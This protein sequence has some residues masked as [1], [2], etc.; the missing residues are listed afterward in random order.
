MTLRKCLSIFCV[1]MLLF[2]FSACSND[3]SEISKSSFNKN[4]GLNDY[5]QTTIDAF[6]NDDIE[7]IK[8]IFCKNVSDSHNLNDEIQNAF[9][10]IDGNIISYEK[11]NSEETGGTRRD[12]ETIRR[13]G[14]SDIVGIKTDSGKSY[15]ILLLCV[16]EYS[17]D[18]SHIGVQDISVYEVNYTSENYLSYDIINKITV[19]GVLD[20]S[21]D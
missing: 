1:L 20:G 16:L 3:I 9:D 12:G 10:F 13:T 21:W 7:T 2:I 5:G 17:E 15:E 11:I 8:N 6:I 18:V 19:G 4:I 14:F